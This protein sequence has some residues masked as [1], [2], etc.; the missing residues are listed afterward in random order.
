MKTAEDKINHY[1]WLDHHIFAFF[2]KVGV[3]KDGNAGIVVAHGDKGYGYKS[4][5]EKEGINFCHGMAIFLL[6]YCR[7]YSKEVRETEEGW[8]DVCEWVIKAYP[9]FKDKLPNL[10]IYKVPDESVI[11]G[12]GQDK[13]YHADASDLQ[14][15]PGQYP[16]YILTEM[17]LFERRELTQDG[18]I[19]KN[20]HYETLRVHND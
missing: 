20:E 15:Q 11:C 8:V 5:W 1:H 16:E 3:K 13:G 17:Y 12:N 10:D 6:S 9:R 14:L 4:R 7:P 19:Y 18:Y 2:E